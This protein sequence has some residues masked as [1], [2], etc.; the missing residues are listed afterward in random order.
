MQNTFVVQLIKQMYYRVIEG[1]DI[2]L[3]FQQAKKEK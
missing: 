1:S 2:F 3:E